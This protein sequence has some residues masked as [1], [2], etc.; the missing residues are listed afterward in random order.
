MAACVTCGERAGIGKVVCASCDTEHKRVKARERA[1]R[2]RDIQER[3]RRQADRKVEKQE[4]N[5]NSFVAACLSQIEEAHR[6]GLNPSL[7]ATRAMSTT[8]SLWGKQAGSPPRVAGFLADLTLGWEVISTIPHTEGVSLTNKTGAG[9]TIYAGGMGGMVTSVY[10]LMRLPITPALMQ[11]KRA[12]IESFG[13]A[14]SL[15]AS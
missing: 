1:E 14:P 8:F 4:E 9:N 10:V 12:Y 3:A 13:T 7:L 6:M 11:E 2:A 15:I 5:L